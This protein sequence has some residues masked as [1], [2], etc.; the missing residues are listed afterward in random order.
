MQSEKDV[1]SKLLCSVADP[2]CLYRILIFSH[3]LPNP[4]CRILDPTTKKEERKQNNLLSY[5]FYVAINL[6]KLKGTYIIFF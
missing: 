6:T 1:L 4:S 2:G 5:L 3:M